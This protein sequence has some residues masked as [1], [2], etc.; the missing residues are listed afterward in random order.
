MPPIMGSVTPRAEPAMAALLLALFASACGDADG[1]GAGG[2]A[3][4]PLVA[5]SSL[6]EPDEGGGP[7]P[8]DSGGIAPAQG[9][10]G[11]GEE[12]QP[13]GPQPYTPRFLARAELPVPAKPVGV[14]A[15]DLDGDGHPDL[16]AVTLD[17]GRLL[18][19]RADDGGL[20][21]HYETLEVGGYP[22]PPVRL[23]APD[24]PRVA[25]ASREEET[26]LLF[27]LA[28]ADAPPVE[29]DLGSRP[30]AL[31]AGDLGADGEPEVVVAF[32]GGTLLVAGTAGERSRHPCGLLRPTFVHLLSDG[33]GA[34][35][36]D[37]LARAVVFVPASELAQG[38]AGQPARV[39][40]L[41]AI[42][43]A[44]A[45]VDIDGDGDDEVVVLGG[46]ASMWV[47]GIERDGAAS[48]WLIDPTLTPQE[49][50]APGSVPIDLEIGDL[51]GEAPDE[52]LTLQYGDSSYG[53]VARLG[54]P[55]GAVLSAPAGQTPWDAALCDVDGDGVLDLAIANRDALR[56]SLL[57]GRG[58]V[59]AGM[60]AFH[61]PLRTPVGITPVSIAV[62][63]LDADARPDAAVLCAGKEELVLLRN[64]FV[65]RPTGVRVAVD[66]SPDNLCIADLD[67]D[68][69]NDLVWT[70]ALSGSARLASRRGDGAGG[71]LPARPTDTRDIGASAYDLLAADLDLDGL[72]ELIVADSAGGVVRMLPGAAGGLGASEPVVFRTG[73]GATALC[74]LQFSGD[75]RPE[76]AIAMGDVEPLTRVLILHPYGDAP[77]APLGAPWHGIRGVPAPIPGAEG[78]GVPRAIAAGDVDGDG[79]DDVVLLVHAGHRNSAGYVHVLLR[80]GD[81]LQ[82]QHPL[83]AGIQPTAIALADANGD[84]R[85]DPF[86]VSQNSHN[87]NWWLTAVNAEGVLAPLRRPD[88]GASY[89]PV[90]LALVDLTLNGAPDVITANAFSDDISVVFNDPTR[91]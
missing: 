74:T 38:G 36:G 78:G 37:Q 84:G 30:H 75:A 1:E 41:D 8:A 67:G 9:A 54:S 66:R 56:V 64:E 82:A 39:F 80:R 13:P 42:P 11:A 89:G 59:R 19:W 7:D 28:R 40:D 62:G 61:E 87:V 21:R 72:A 31:G 55:Q 86:C 16:A 34:L 15:G 60:P 32:L 6:L 53:I 90:D 10:D 50:P 77:R 83:P 46:E 44:A 26:L 71:L 63:H 2:P 24:G 14:L 88:L 76:V 25:V 69:A 58:Q 52:L 12:Q 70:H 23:D 85:A 91:P 79:L 43:R 29:I 5:P 68:G 3:G 65:L 33:G 45:E 18:V 51:D 17:P 81:G 4:G 20:P 47:F 48:G 57:R 27:D 73:A 35:I 22:L 49:L